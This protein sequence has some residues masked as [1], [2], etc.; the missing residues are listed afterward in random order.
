VWNY[1]VSIRNNGSVAQ[2]TYQVKLYKEG[3]VELSSVAGTTIAPLQTLQFS[4]P[5]TPATAGATFIYAKVFLAGDQIAVNDQS[6]NYPVV[7]QEAGVV[8]V[9]VGT[10]G[11]VGKYPL[12]M[13]YKASLSET[14][15]LA[16]ELNI[17]GL[18]TGIQYYNNFVT[19]LPNKP[20]K[21]WAGETQLENLSTGWIPST[22]LTLVYDGTVNYPLGQNN[23]TIPFTTPL[24]YGGGN[25]AI[26]VERPL[27]AAYFSSSDNFVTQ[28]V[29][30]N[31]TRKVQSDTIVYDPA[32]PPTA[33]PTGIFPKTTFF[34]ITE[35][36]GALNGTVTVNGTPLAGAR[37][38]VANSNLS[39][40]TG[41][42]GTYSFP[43]ITEGLQVVSAT[44]HGYNVVTHNVTIVE[45]QT[46]T[47]DFAVSLLPQV[48][49]TGR[50]VGSDQPT[51]GLPGTIALSGYENYNATAD[52]SGNFTLTNVYANQTYSYLVGALGYANTT[53]Q[54]VVGS[55]DVNLG[56]VVVNEIANPVNTVVATEAANFSNV[57]VTWNEPGQGGG[58]WIHY[59][60]GENDDSIGTGGAADFD[61]AIRYPA[62]ALAD[63]AGMSLYSL[64]VWPAQAGT[65]ALRVWTGGTATAPATMVVDQPFTPTLDTYNTVM[66]N[67]PVL[68]TG[69]Q[70]L[71]FGYRCNVTTGFP[72]GVDAGPA[73]NGFG[74]MIY[75]QGAWTTLTAL[76]A[77]LNYNW[78]I[79]GY[80]GY[81]APTR[82]AKLTPLAFNSNRIN[83]GTLT[84]SGIENKKN[85][86]V[87]SRSES[88]D[89]VRV[90]YKVWRL[91]SADQANETAW[92]SLTPNY[93]TELTYTDNAWQPLPSGV[94][95]FAVKAV[96][97]ND[98][99][100]NPAFSN[101]IHKGM[102]GV[103]S[104][105]V[106]DF[107]NGSPVAGAV[108]RAGTYSGT[109]DAQGAYS[110]GV[111]QG[112]YTVTCTKP[113]FLPYSQA[114]VSI[115]GLQTTTVNIA[116][117][118]IPYPPNNVVA[119]ETTDFQ[120]V[121]LTWAAPDPNTAPVE[122]FESGNLTAFPWVTGGDAPWFVTDTDAHAG[123]NSATNGDI[124]HNQASNLEITRNVL[125][126][127]NI[128]FWYKVSSES[129][130]DFL[131]FYING[132]E[133]GS[134]SGTVAWTQA[135]YPV[136]LG[137]NTF[138]WVYSKDVS[139][140]AG[141]D[142]AWID[143]VTFPV[144]SDPV[145]IT[146]N[147]TNPNEAQK[148]TKA[149][150]QDNET[151]A[152]TRAFVG[153]RVWRLL[154]AD[155][156][157][158]NAWTSL[159]PSSITPTQFTDNTWQPL[160]SGVY[161][162]AVKAVYSNDVFSLP[163]FSNEVHKGM[164][165]VLTGE[166]TEF[167]TNLPVAGATVT[168]GTYSG[169]TN[170]SGVYSFG[171]Y[172]GTYNVVAAKPGY[173]PASQAGVVIVGMQ[174]TNQNFVLTELTL[175]PTAVQAALAGNNVNI[176]WSAPGGGGT[177]FTE[178]FESYPNFAISFAPWTLVDVD[179]STTY[180][181]TGTTWTNAYAAQAY[182]IFNPSATTPAL[183]TVAT[184]GGA[185]MAACFAALLPA[186]GGTG[187]NN[188]WL[189][190]PQVTVM[191]GDV[192]NFW[193]RSHTAEYGLERFKVGVSTTGTAPA[194]F[195]IISG[196]NYVSAP[197][198][199]TN[200]NYSLSAYAGQQ[201]Y[202][203]IQC[204]SNDA[205]IFFVDDFL[206][207]A[208]PARDEFIAQTND[209]EVLTKMNIY[210]QGI[211]QLKANEMKYYKPSTGVVSILPSIDLSSLV[212]IDETRAL[213]GYK[214][215]RLISGQE[216]NETGWTSLTAN[217]IS[218]TAY[219]DTGWGAL[220]DGTYKW[221]VKAVYT[222]GALSIPALSNPLTKMTQIGTIAGIVR[223]QQNQA[224]AGATVTSGTY[225]AT[226]NTNGA[227]SII[228]PA[229]THSVT[230]SHA[231]YAPSTQTGIIVLTGQTTTVNFILAPTQ[232]L[233]VDGFETYANF[234]LTFA[235]WTLVDVDLSVTYGIENV[236][237]QNSGA[238]MAYI[239]FNP[240]ATTPA[241]TTSVPHGGAKMAA[242]FAAILPAQG[243]TG[244]NNDWL[245]TPQVT[246]AAQI[247]FWAKSHT[248]QYGLERFKVGV[249]TTGTAP[250][251][252]TII[253][254]A[255]YISAPID[256]TEYTYNLA[257]GNTPIRIGIQCISNDAFIFFVD[258][259]LITGGGTAN[260]DITVPVVATELK[261]NY[262]NPFNPETTIAFN[263]KETSEVSIE[264]YNVK[265]QLVK[266]LL[267]DVKDAGS[268]S[269]IWNGKDNNG[270]AV[271]SGIYYYKMN[272]GKYS[273]TK[274]M[275]MM[276]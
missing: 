135:T 133:M 216:T 80:V 88:K 79:Q 16:S 196:A 111:Y 121:N 148:A 95:K 235:P 245:I 208:P 24:P 239:I 264:I 49:I 87:V 116:L 1:N 156:A 144:S 205:F 4:L 44:K 158:E 193:A 113:G 21:I 15:Y 28:T 90:G 17:G 125:V 5:W 154:A 145:R 186:Q 134:W 94:Y 224:I 257:Y 123:T 45:D 232:N 159:T 150:N 108:V 31:R 141:S 256:W 37:V 249:S 136:A 160:P 197:I 149:Q 204:I 112:S 228:V 243:G 32:A 161:K 34:F 143:D 207:G 275:I 124:T 182:I 30:T 41:A 164:M 246:G 81:D 218:A 147:R 122:D 22:A 153:Y 2:N 138:K 221:A 11:S 176:T 35:G 82:G 3:N 7:V 93:I 219:Q 105:T 174:T 195:T 198:D 167:G 75:W 29:G 9:T 104:G 92:T 217:P 200:Y 42:N 68:I 223:N 140:D 166:V 226:T 69:N 25:L 242:S 236:T 26:M 185:K 251:N 178:D 139:D 130:Y 96:Y 180:G 91:L 155:Q 171:V 173:Q 106:T 103:L 187:P 18:L 194:N 65:F 137:N 20:T 169:I 128:S 33:T 233:L 201:V 214:V 72:A 168:A 241:V 231:N 248:A 98:V 210:T 240:S 47:Q 14:V 181:M 238:A 86:N 74:N 179:L 237:F 260:E 126:A 132:A 265:G 73:T 36:M 118:E 54:V 189:I 117:T 43:Y 247:K 6:P 13:F 39:Y 273:S 50:I 97:T 84:T 67:T 220:P 99:M 172:A 274:K 177:G 77:D 57:V 100:S 109:S 66:L 213:T 131:K 55:V 59:D 268:H 129:N 19:D 40:T 259:V 250:A 211:G 270:R 234:A 71:W 110:F 254:G 262:P 222:G 227:Y 253:S 120:L 115:T 51:I 212:T 269:V 244:P 157:N 61:V 127:G 263:M 184:H 102:M 10:G 175:P 203:G 23:I 146:L 48:T 255:N 114:N 272:T 70:E 199:W 252:F 8:A 162:F 76:S 119:T 27:D 215:W 64:K 192:V 188:D 206:I 62:S 151:D 78:N 83:S 56:D 53:G 229:G 142:C 258:D 107:G 170:T 230:A 266:T 190:S 89:R 38:T 261:T 276:K 163:A 52:A 191:P 85:V 46:T 12:D 183:T 209:Q 165:G 271:S 152:T 60:S 225:T 267:N 58:E 202:V 63:Y 101:E